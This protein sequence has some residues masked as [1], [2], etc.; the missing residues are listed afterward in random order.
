MWSRQSAWEIKGDPVGDCIEVLCKHMCTCPI[1]L[2]ELA[3]DEARSLTLYCR[4]FSHSH[5]RAEGSDGVGKNLPLINGMA[6]RQRLG[7]T[8]LWNL[9]VT[10]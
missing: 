3:P 2:L 8:V 10:Y 5:T 6:E 4:S 7:I 1:A 9:H